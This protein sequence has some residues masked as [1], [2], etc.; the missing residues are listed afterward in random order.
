MYIIGDGIITQ[1]VFNYETE[2]W[3]LVVEVWP[4]RS[5]INRN[6]LKM[7]EGGEVDSLKLDGDDLH[8]EVSN[9]S[10]IYR[11]RHDLAAPN[12]FDVPMDKITPE[13]A[14][15]AVEVKK[16]RRRKK[17]VKKDKAS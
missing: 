6:L 10:A 4:E 14:A 8:I 16:P 13:E 3:D 2:D 1:R 5:A 9:G 15:A 17:A 7:V 12:G 11:L